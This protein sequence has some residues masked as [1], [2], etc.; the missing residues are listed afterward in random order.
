MGLDTKTDWLA[1]DHD[2]T[3][4]MKAAGRRAVGLGRRK[5]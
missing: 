4:T 5:K 3:L 1:V 2:I